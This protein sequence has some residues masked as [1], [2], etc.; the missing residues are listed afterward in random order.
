[1]LPGLFVD[2]ALLGFGRIL[3]L[4]LDLPGRFQGLLGRFQ[5]GLVVGGFVGGLITAGGTRRQQGY[6]GNQN[7]AGQGFHGGG[8]EVLRSGLQKLSDRCG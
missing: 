2:F 8:L 3:Q 7:N 4:L 5:Q 6:N 1:M